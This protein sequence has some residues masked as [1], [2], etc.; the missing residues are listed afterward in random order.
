MNSDTS[1]DLFS[2]NAIMKIRQKPY[3]EAEPSAFLYKQK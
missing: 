3:K 1:I 2:K